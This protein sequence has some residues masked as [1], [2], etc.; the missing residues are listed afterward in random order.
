MNKPV[1]ND[2]FMGKYRSPSAH[3]GGYL[4]AYESVGEIYHPNGMIVKLPQTEFFV[5]ETRLRRKEAV[6]EFER[7]PVGSYYK[8]EFLD[9]PEQDREIYIYEKTKEGWCEVAHW[10][11]EGYKGNWPAHVIKLPETES[12][13]QELQAGMRKFGLS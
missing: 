6:V 10:S 7:A 12:I 2:E 3:K 5:N 13:M 4:H 11:E 9:E 8:R 1:H